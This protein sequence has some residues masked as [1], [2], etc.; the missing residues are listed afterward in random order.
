MSFEP[1]EILE[2]ETIGRW[3]DVGIRDK[4]R[5]LLVYCDTF[6]WSHYPVYAK[7]DAGYWCKR[8]NPL[9]SRSNMQSLIQVYDLSMNKEAQLAEHRALH[10]PIAGY[11]FD[12]SLPSIDEAPFQYD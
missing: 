5:Y 9:Y 1:Y 7:D 11:I 2:R 12:K 6:D 8:D 4:Q 3:F 10:G